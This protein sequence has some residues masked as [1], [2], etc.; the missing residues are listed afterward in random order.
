[1][2]KV[3]AGLL[4]PRPA[5]PR[6]RPGPGGGGLREGLFD[7][8]G[9]ADLRRERQRPDRAPGLGQ[10]LL[11]GPGRQERQGGRAA[12]TLRLTE[13]RVRKVGDEIRV[14]T[15]NP[16]AGG[17]SD[18]STSAAGT[19]TSTTSSR[20]RPAPRRR[21]ETC[22]GRVTAVGIRG[23]LL[24]RRGQ[25]LDRAART[26]RARQGLD[27]QRLGPPR[28]QGSAQEGTARDGQ[29]LRRRRVRPRLLGPVRPGDRQRPHRGRLRPGGRGQVRPQGGPRQLQRRRR[30]APLRDGQRHDPPQDRQLSRAASS[31]RSAATA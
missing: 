25:R 5:G 1:M 4:L 14:E 15:I 19:R 31:R 24:E 17:S 16:N 30:G 7:G 6:C 22:N 2:R 3:L 9:F 8:G 29:R 27:G 11:Q 12:E 23:R 26:S 20:F 21:L 10:A 13:I 18:S 28:L